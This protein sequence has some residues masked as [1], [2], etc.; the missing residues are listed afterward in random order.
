MTTAHRTGRHPAVKLT[1]QLARG[2]LIDLDGV[3]G[4]TVTATQPY[5][6]QALIRLA[7]ASLAVICARDVRWH[8]LAPDVPWITP[9]TLEALIP[10]RMQ[11]HGG[12]EEVPG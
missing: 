12:A 4:F 8:A 9:G 5:G 1:T 6:T 10:G 2:D 7:T 3:G 11:G